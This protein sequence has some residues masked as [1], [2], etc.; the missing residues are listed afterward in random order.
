MIDD[1]GT[2]K[3]GFD[4]FLGRAIKD[5]SQRAE[6]ESL[7]RPAQMDFKHLTD[8]HASRHAQRIQNDINRRSIFEERH[9]FHGNNFGNDAFIAVASCHLI[10]GGD[11]AALSNRNTHHHIHARRKVGIIFA[12]KDF[13]IYYLAAFAMRHSQRCIFYV[14]GLLAKDGAEQTLFRR[15]FLFAFGRDLTD[16]NIIRSNFRS[17]AD[18]SIL[19]QIL[20]RIFAHVGNI[21]RDLFR[22]QLGIARLH[23]IFLDMNRSETI[24]LHQTLREQNGV[25]EVE[26]FP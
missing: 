21:A 1:P 9:V 5:R 6:A 3:L 16:E 7:R 8:I 12:C 25:F 4:L 19:I 11:L 23:F 15:K 20:D 2:R 14:A 17:D 18:D 13:H 10:S 22:A 26:A 24:L